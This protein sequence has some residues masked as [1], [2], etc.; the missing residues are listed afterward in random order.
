MEGATDG[1]ILM[2]GTTDGACLLAGTTYVDARTAV[3]A[4]VS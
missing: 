4:L 1:L 2:L 3:K